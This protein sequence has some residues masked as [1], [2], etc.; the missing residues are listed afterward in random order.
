MSNKRKNIIGLMGNAAKRSKTAD[1][2]E[3]HGF[4]RVSIINKVKEL[5]MYIKGDLN[6]LR[7]KGYEVN[8]YYWINLLLSS[9]PPDITK[10]V[11]ED[12]EMNDVVNNVLDAYL[13][14]N[15]EDKLE[16]IA[17]GIIIVSNDNETEALGKI[18]SNT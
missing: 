2:L 12:L 11:I 10:I 1:F 6:E 16:N 9:I 3:K 17:A 15:P 5:S 7:K 18:I 8:R 13:F 14:V 4:Y